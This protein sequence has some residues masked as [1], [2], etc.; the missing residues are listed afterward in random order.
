MGKR[1]IRI[2]VPKKAPKVEVTK[3]TYTRKVKHKNKESK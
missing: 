1:K 2:P 3:K